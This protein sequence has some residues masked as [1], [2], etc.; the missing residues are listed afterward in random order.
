MDVTPLVSKGRQLIESYGDGAFKISGV[1]YTA[2]LLYFPS[3][4]FS[5]KF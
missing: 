4:F 2:L 5:R 1:V 3:P